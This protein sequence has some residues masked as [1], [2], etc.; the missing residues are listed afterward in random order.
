MWYKMIRCCEGEVFGKWLL[1]LLWED[2]GSVFEMAVRRSGRMIL[3]II[4]IHETNKVYIKPYLLMKYA[5]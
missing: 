2:V 4:I 5:L 1:Q 3:I